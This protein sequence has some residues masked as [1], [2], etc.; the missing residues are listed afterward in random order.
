MRW[1]IDQQ[2]KMGGGG[3]GGLKLSKIE[4]KWQLVKIMV[5]VER[6]LMKLPTFER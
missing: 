4:K 6:F 1:F 3:G 2:G 5:L